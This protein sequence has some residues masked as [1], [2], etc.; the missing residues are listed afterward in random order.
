MNTPNKT[1]ITVEVTINA[2]ID[3]VWEMFNA[4]EHMTQWNAASDDWH[5]PY[6]NN[7]LREG[8]R[9]ICTMA[10][11]NGSMSFDFLATYNKIIPHKLI[12]Y[13]LD[14]DRKVSISFSE[15]GEQVTIIETFEAE[16]T[17]SIEL[18]H[19]GWQAILSNFKKYVESH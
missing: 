1:S 8:G 4:P 13:T 3:K 19:Q 9:L 11:K 2:P 14:D 18:Q 5:A 10:A 16:A 7:D 15:H 6:A 12:E 17:H